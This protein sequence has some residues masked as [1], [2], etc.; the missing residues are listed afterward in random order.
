STDWANFFHLREHRDAEPHFYDLAVMIREA[1]EAATPQSLNPGDWH[2]PFV[3]QSDADFA[4]EATGGDSEKTRKTLIKLSVARCARISYKPFDGDGSIE[5]EMER[6]EK[7][8]G[9]SPLH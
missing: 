8:V 1:I 7:L 3:E 6:Y 5:K 4:R 2:L 9:S